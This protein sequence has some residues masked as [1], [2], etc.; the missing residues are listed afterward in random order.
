MASVVDAFL[1][2]HPKADRRSGRELIAL[3][4][5]RVLSK[6]RDWAIV[7]SEVLVPVSIPSSGEGSS[8]S[9][10]G[11]AKVTT[12]T[13]PAGH[14]LGSP[15]ITI[16]HKSSAI[17]KDAL[18]EYRV[19][20]PLDKSKN[21]KITTGRNSHATTEVK[22]GVN[23]ARTEMK[24]G[25][26]TLFG[27][28]RHGTLSAYGLYPD[29]LAGKPDSVLKQI[30]ADLT[31]TVKHATQV[32]TGSEYIRAAVADTPPFRETELDSLWARETGKLSVE[33]F[34]TRARTDE[35]FCALLRR[36]AAL[37]RAREVFLT[38][39]LGNPELL[40][41][42]RQ[43]EAIVFT[44]I[45]LVTPDPFRNFLAK[46]FP[47]KYRMH[48]ELSMRREE[49][50]A[51]QDL[52]EAINEGQ[53]EIDGKMVKGEIISFST[54]VNRLALHGWGAP[55]RALL[56]G[57][58]QVQDDNLQAIEQMIGNPDKVASNSFGG[59]LGREIT[60]RQ[61]QRQALQAEYDQIESALGQ[62]KKNGTDRLERQKKILL[63]LKDM[64]S[65]VAELKALGRQLAELWTS[66]EY[67]HAGAQP[68]K[69]AARIARLSFLLGAGTAF[70]CKSGKDRTAQLDLE[71][72]LLSVQSEFRRSGSG[73]RTDGDATTAEEIPPSYGERSAEALHQMQAFVFQDETR[74]VMQRYNTGA[75]G[76]KLGYWQALY[77][78]F[79]APGTD[80]EFIG[81]EFRGRSAGVKS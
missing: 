27:G 24:A 2:K 26:E 64:E 31:R 35:S 51:W 33:Q 17:N 78:S 59:A 36:K 34:I 62:K 50:Q 54:G 23:V 76:S 63:Q 80:A 58:N 18:N 41:R 11:V 68:Y 29:T 49:K 67:R 38:E 6:E 69:F 66:G 55:G 65:K 10:A 79:I 48:D 45:S 16:V 15:D 7:Q 71:V 77:D 81:S 39:A 60:R 42:I 19:P 46:L 57:W 14:V 40:Q 72:K 52:Q 3:A 32:C 73:H 56:S 53:I 9:P 25:G 37:N 74:T 70:N 12:V 13:T 61:Q 22:H 47:K 8:Q 28:T 4:R 75:E 43:G 44:S 21:R 30:H 1:E 20:D 5:N